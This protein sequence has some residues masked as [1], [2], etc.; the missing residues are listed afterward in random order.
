MSS[1]P[2]PTVV[3]R[4]IAL[5]AIA[6]IA[7]GWLFW[8]HGLEMA[9]LAHFSADIVLHVVAPLAGSLAR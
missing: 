7:F 1:I 4:T 2:A 9:M 5:N 3:V 6:G 8:K